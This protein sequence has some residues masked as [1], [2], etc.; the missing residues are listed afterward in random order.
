MPRGGKRKN[1]GRKSEGETKTFLLRISPQLHQALRFRAQEESKSLNA[2][3]GEIL[4]N[5]K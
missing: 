3:I 4:E 1:A 5:G 2:L